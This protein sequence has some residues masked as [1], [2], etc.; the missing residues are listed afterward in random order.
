MLPS[1]NRD[2]M[3]QSSLNSSSVSIPRRRRL[4]TFERK[5]ARRDSSCWFLKKI[6]LLLNK[7]IETAGTITAVRERFRTAVIVLSGPLNLTD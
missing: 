5:R 6:G 1:L 7:L 2:S 3:R 4:R